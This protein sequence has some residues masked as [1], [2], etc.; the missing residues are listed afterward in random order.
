MFALATGSGSLAASGW[1]GC[2]ADEFFVAL[3]R[4]DSTGGLAAAPLA[5]NGMK[6]RA[7]FGV[8]V[9]VFRSVAMMAK[10]NKINKE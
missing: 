5:L 6:K 8:V 1:H 7:V 4:A 3:L 9:H 2:L 10:K